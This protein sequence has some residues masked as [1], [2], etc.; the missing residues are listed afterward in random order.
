M[1]RKTFFDQPN[2][3]NKDLQSFNKRLNCL[4]ELRE[5]KNSRI[6][7]AQLAKD[8]QARVKQAKNAKKATPIVDDTPIG[9]AMEIKDKDL[10]K[11]L[12]WSHE[13]SKQCSAQQD[14]IDEIYLEK[15]PIAASLNKRKR[16]DMPVTTVIRDHGQRQ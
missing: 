6:S 7:G 1:C 8:N 5:S 14:I 10:A 13:N 11:N 3:I 9:Q 12:K 2:P 16:G 4:P 15:D